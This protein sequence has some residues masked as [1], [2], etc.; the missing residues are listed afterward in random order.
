MFNKLADFFPEFIIIYIVQPRRSRKLEFRF[1]P[2]AGM[3][4][5]IT[6]LVKVITI[7]PYLSHCLIKEGFKILQI[8]VRKITGRTHR[9][10]MSE[11]LLIIAFE[12]YGITGDVSPLPERKL[13]FKHCHLIGN[14]GPSYPRECPSPTVSHFKEH[15]IKGIKFFIGHFLEPEDPVTAFSCAHVL[16]KRLHSGVFRPEVEWCHVWNTDI[17]IIRVIVPV[18]H[19]C[20]SSLADTGGCPPAPEN[21]FKELN[22]PVMISSCLPGSQV[23]PV[24]RI[25]CRLLEISVLNPDQVGIQD[26]SKLI[27]ASP[28]AVS[29]G[30]NHNRPVSTGIIKE[31]LLGKLGTVRITVVNRLPEAYLPRLTECSVCLYPEKCICREARQ[32]LLQGHD[33]L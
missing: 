14:F 24:N 9:C 6:K 12:R 11:Y 20:L 32:T 29:L 4:D 31:Y 10:H 5:E 17:Y 7:I 19:H 18:E 2:V 28:G 26:G 27:P 1:F 23:F 33:L 30:L 15:G 22:D 3:P 13:I 25:G 8:L 16:K 21:G